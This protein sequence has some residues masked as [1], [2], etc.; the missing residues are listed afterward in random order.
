MKAKKK[1]ILLGALALLDCVFGGIVISSSLASQKYVKYNEIKTSANYVFA[2]NINDVGD[3]LKNKI[4]ETD[5]YNDALQVASVA[6]S[7]NDTQQK[8]IVTTQKKIASD[9]K[10]AAATAKKATTT[11]KTSKLSYVSSSASAIES[12]A[13]YKAVQAKNTWKGAKLSRSAGVVTGPSGKETYYNLNMS[14]VVKIMRARGNKDPYW[15]RSDGV[16]M[17]GNYVMVAANLN[18]RPRGSIVPTSL[19]LGIVCDTGSFASKNPTQLD[20]AVAW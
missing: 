13:T 15:V 8:L 18:I 4:D 5:K 16:K 12:S 17:L 20:I 7:A 10:K 1:T 11:T 3:S 6:T 19:G 9:K 14:G 2:Q